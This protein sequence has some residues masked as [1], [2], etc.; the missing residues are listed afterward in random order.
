MTKFS[1][2][3]MSEAMKD[4]VTAAF[5]LFILVFILA[6][7]EA[8][9][10]NS[11]QLFGCTAIGSFFSF[12]LWIIYS[13]SVIFLFGIALIIRNS[14]FF[15][16]FIKLALIKYCE[17]AFNL[18]FSMSGALFALTIWYP[19]TKNSELL[20]KLSFA[21]IFMLSA[22]FWLF[23]SKLCLHINEGT[24]AIFKYIYGEKYS[25]AITLLGFFLIIS[26]FFYIYEMKASFQMF[27]QC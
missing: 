19:I 22:F 10:F 21:V 20:E 3:S 26:S 6:A 11:I 8:I 13:A 14:N 27:V 4:G 24:G 23:L 17:L 9:P 12:G 1:K 18:T 5:P 15:S 16:N 7:M 25:T 2:F